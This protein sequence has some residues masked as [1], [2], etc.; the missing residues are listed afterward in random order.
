MRQRD[1]KALEHDHSFMIMWHLQL[2]FPLTV[3]PLHFDW[4]SWW[5]VLNTVPVRADYSTFWSHRWPNFS[6][7]LPLISAASRPADTKNLLLPEKRFIFFL[8]FP[9]F[10]CLSVTL[11]TLCAV[12]THL[13]TCVDEKTSIFTVTDTR[14]SGVLAGFGV[15]CELCPGGGNQA[16]MCQLLY[17]QIP[18]SIAINP[19]VPWW[20]P[21]VAVLPGAICGKDQRLWRGCDAWEETNGRKWF[22]TKQKQLNATFCGTVNSLVLPSCSLIWVNAGAK[23]TLKQTASFLICVKCSIR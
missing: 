9:Q 18:G 11:N 16:V 13:N 12:K 4:E 10:I 5:E 6:A 22:T 20:D 8:V 3:L 1:Q 19:I 7:F 17:T 23:K 15:S 2:R 14:S 21:L